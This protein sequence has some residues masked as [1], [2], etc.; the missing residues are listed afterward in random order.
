MFN[1]FEVLGLPTHATTQVIRS[2]Y[3][4]LLKK[5]HPDTVSQNHASE[6]TLQGIMNAYTILKDDFLRGVFLQ[7]VDSG[8]S[9]GTEQEF[10]AFA[11]RFTPQQVAPT[12]PT[13]QERKEKVSV[14]LSLEESLLGV[15]KKIVCAKSTVFITIPMNTQDRVTVRYKHQESLD[16]MVDIEVM[17]FVAPHPFL[18]REGMNLV[19]RCPISF[20]ESVGGATVRIP[21][22]YEV[23]DVHI[24]A[25]SQG[26]NVVVPEKGVRGAPS[27]NLV[28][29][30]EIVPPPKDSP[31]VLSIIE[32]EKTKTYDPRST[33]FQKRSQN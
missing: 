13:R 27:G 24:P 31:L 6:K 17:V 9:F 21:T 22:P 33:F 18:R 1:P 2:R 26:E 16:S 7:S 32:E 15:Q 28:V 30:P 25:F 4:Q 10:R 20:A 8:L 11:A 12:Q 29:V 5:L 14:T 3:A 19:C 23:V